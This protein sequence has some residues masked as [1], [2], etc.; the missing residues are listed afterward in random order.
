MTTDAPELWICR[1]ANGMTWMT[2]SEP[3]DFNSRMWDLGTEGAQWV[4]PEMFDMTPG[5]KARL[6]METVA[7]ATGAST[8][9]STSGATTEP[10]SSVV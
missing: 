1:D 10:T 3:T 2:K 5:T 8:G 6:R 9:E 7:D 4:R